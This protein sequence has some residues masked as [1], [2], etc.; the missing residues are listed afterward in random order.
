[1]FD[2]LIWLAYDHYI[3]VFYLGYAS[4]T[5]TINMHRD[6]KNETTADGT[7]ANFNLTLWNKTFISGLRL[8]KGL[9][10]FFFT[11]LPASNIYIEL[12]IK[13][14]ILRKGLTFYLES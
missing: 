11:V 12:I 7:A 6:W 14:I 1:L 3:I 8:P 9:L 2:I 13:I 5:H 10:F 4:F